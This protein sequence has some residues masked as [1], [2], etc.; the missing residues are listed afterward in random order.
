MTFKE[1][2]EM[3][4]DIGY[5]YS[6]YQFTQDT[7]QAPPFICYYYEGNNDV[8]ADD[9]NYQKIETLIVELYTDSKDFAAEAAIEAALKGAGL[10]WSREESVINSEKLYMVI[11]Q[12]DVII[13]EV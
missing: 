8:I 5:P 3:I 7:A 13:T 2:A 11:Y 12:S 10:V 9:S 4:K 1:V 6:Y